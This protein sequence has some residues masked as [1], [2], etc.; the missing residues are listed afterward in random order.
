MRF[1]HFITLVCGVVIAIT[2]VGYWGGKI[3]AQ[4]KSTND[5]LNALTV[6]VGKLSDKLDAHMAQKA[7]ICLPECPKDKIT[8]ATLNP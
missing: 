3:E 5:G 2:A 1:I 4:Q 7:A 8:M 6:T